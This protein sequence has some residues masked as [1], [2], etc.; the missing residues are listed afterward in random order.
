MPLIKRYA[1]RKLYDT[2][3]K[4]YITLDGIAELIRQ[5]QEVKVIDH[6]TG[7]DITAVTQAQIIFEQERKIKGGLPRALF[8][9]LIQTGNTTLSQ[10]RHAVFAPTEWTTEVDAEIERRVQQLIQS[11]R[12]SDDEGLHIL[13]VLITPIEPTT[14]A[15]PAPPIAGQMERVIKSRGISTRA[16]LAQ[17]TR[18]IEALTAEVDSLAKPKATRARK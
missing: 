10:L 4:R 3:A 14:P 9:N 11:N 7:E 18:Q 1:N 5:E 2:E 13:D 17:L 15:A 8:T 16:D 6:A 12:I